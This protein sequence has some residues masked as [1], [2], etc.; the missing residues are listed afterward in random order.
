MEAYWEAIVHCRPGE[1]YNIG[2]ATSMSVGEFLELLIKKS[3]VPIPT[4]VD[5]G[6]LRPADVTLQIP[7]VEKFVKETGWKPKYSI[8]ESMQHLL[9]FWRMEAAQ[10]R[11]SREPNTMGEENEGLT[12]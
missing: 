3:T 11:R 2:G 12:L 7:S 4:K 5:P 8:E 9:A 1:A 6:L 10:E